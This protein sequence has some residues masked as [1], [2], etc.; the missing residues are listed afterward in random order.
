VATLPLSFRKKG[1]KDCDFKVSFDREFVLE[2]MNRLRNGWTVRQ[3]SE[4]Q[5]ERTHPDDYEVARVVITGKEPSARAQSSMT[6][7]CHARAKPAWQATAGDVDTAC[8]PSIVA[9]MLAA[10]RIRQRGVLP[11]EIGPR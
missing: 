9:Q 1:L 8:P 4:L 6:M 7:D 5:A 10:G 3:L 11:P 2:V